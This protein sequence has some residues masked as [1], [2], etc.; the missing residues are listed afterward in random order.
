M[1]GEH[2]TIVVSYDVTDAQ[3]ATVAQTATITVAGT[4]DTPTVTI[5]ALRSDVDHPGEAPSSQALLTKH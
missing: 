5:N 3:G 2:T 1:E 4:D